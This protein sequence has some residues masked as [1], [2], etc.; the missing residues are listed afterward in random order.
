VDIQV[1]LVLQAIVEFLGI[2]VSL[3]LVGIQDKVEFQATQVNQ[4]Q[5]VI[6]ARV[7]LRATQVNQELLDTLEFRVTVV[8]VNLGHQDIL[9]TAELAAIL[10]KVEL[11]VIAEF[12]VIQDSLVPVD[13][14]DKVA[15]LVIVVSQEL[16]A[17]VVSREHLDILVTVEQADILANQEFLVTAELRDIQAQVVILV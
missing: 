7:G 13:T 16:Q 11:L 9:V 4:V 12:L 2:R 15:H 17:I 3:E 10:V 5:V 8:L 1:S 6:Q 14:L